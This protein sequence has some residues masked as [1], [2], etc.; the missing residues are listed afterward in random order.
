MPPLNQLKHKNSLSGPFMS[1][2]AINQ[3][4]YHR[5]KHITCCDVDKWSTVIQ[6]FES[7]NEVK[8]KYPLNDF[9][10]KLHFISEISRKFSATLFNDR[11]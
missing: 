10:E 11:I 1:L 5:C 4:S 2:F 7:E 9:I 3:N 8:F 6:L